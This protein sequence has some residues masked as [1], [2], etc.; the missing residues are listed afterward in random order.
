MKKSFDAKAWA[1]QRDEFSR[2]FDGDCFQ[3]ARA[4]LAVCARKIANNEADQMEAKELNQ[5]SLAIRKTQEIGRMAM[6]ETTDRKQLDLDF[7]G[8]FIVEFNDHYSK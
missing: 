8:E 1:E 3:V 7:G 4:L 2:E 6:G 5:L